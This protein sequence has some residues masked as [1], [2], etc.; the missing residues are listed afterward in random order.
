LS[1]S[2]RRARSS[3]GLLL[4]AHLCTSS[5][6]QL[7]DIEEA[8]LT[9]SAAGSNASSSGSSNG[10]PLVGEGGGGASTIEPASPAGNAG[11]AAG[12]TGDD[13]PALCERYC[14]TVTESCSGTFAVYTSLATCREV[15]RALPPGQA[16]DTRGNSVECRL[17]A[18]R[19][20]SN[21]PAHYC[22]T[23]GPGGNG[24]CGSNCEGLCRI[25]ASVCGAFVEADEATCLS[26]CEELPDLGHYS[27]DVKAGQYG[28]P[29][30][31]C[32]LYHVSAAA[33]EDAEQHCPHVDG[34]APCN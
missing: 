21:E 11:V 33:L 8:E 28:G 20:A 24:V 32:R 19:V 22:P 14:L 34:A 2:A 18:A 15:C 30:V 16:G 10:S 17:H 29:H 12:G 23:A 13:E 1:A 27:T 4:G 7:L 31:Q 6:R 3:F 25:R 26:D 5:C 9:P